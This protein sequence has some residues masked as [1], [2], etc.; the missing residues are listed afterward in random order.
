MEERFVSYLNIGNEI[1]NPE[2]YDYIGE[3]TFSGMQKFKIK[4]INL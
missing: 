4:N 3:D 2:K 1:P